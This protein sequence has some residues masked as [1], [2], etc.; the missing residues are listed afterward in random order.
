[1]SNIN[2]VAGQTV[3]NAVVATPDAQGRVCVHAFVPTHVVVDVS[4]TFS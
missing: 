1:V 4:G 2:F 3:A